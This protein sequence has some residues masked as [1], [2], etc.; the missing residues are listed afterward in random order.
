MTDGALINRFLEIIQ[1]VREGAET[2]REKELLDEVESLVDQIEEP[3]KPYSTGRFPLSP[4]VN[5]RFPAD[6]KK[7]ADETMERFKDIRYIKEVSIGEPGEI[8]VVTAHGCGREE[9]ENTELNLTS[10]SHRRTT[11]RVLLVK[12]ELGELVKML[13][14]NYPIVRVDGERV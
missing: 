10:I 13:K 11:E 12:G 14:R 8:H 5:M 1:E 6:S 3:E 7:H 9:I 4:L 2:D